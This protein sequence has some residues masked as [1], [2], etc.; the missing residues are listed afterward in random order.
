MA[1]AG[2]GIN[3]VRGTCARPTVHKLTSRRRME[4]KARGRRL[5]QW[6]ERRL[7][8]VVVL[9]KRQ[10]RVGVGVG[11]QVV[12]D[13]EVCR[14]WIALLS[15]GFPVRVGRQ[16]GSSSRE[17]S[18]H[19]SWPGRASARLRSVEVELRPTTRRR[20][21]VVELKLHFTIATISIH[22]WSFYATVQAV[23]PASCQLRTS[24]IWNQTVVG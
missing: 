8:T 15:D 9:F 22:Q 14:F 3:R 24:G 5:D 20:S 4:E 2:R 7:K 11:G 6:R 12:T 1:A 17:S 13:G 18:A 23:Q 16:P 19:S 21:T 10:A